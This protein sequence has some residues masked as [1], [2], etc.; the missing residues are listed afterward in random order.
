MS[1]RAKR[2]KR[3]KRMYRI[4]FERGD[5]VSEHGCTYVKGAATLFTRREANV[6]ANENLVYPADIFHTAYLEDA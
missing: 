5:Y 6:W 4:R 2:A 1:K 3:A